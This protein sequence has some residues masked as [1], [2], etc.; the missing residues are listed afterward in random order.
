MKDQDLQ[1]ISSKQ[2]KWMLIG[3][4][5][6]ALILIA[7]S[8]LNYSCLVNINSKN[9]QQSWL[10][11]L[12]Y[13]EQ[14]RGHDLT[15]TMQGGLG[16]DPQRLSIHGTTIELSGGGAVDLAFLTGPQGSSGTVGP[17]GLAGSNGAI[18]T[19]GP[20]GPV[21]VAIAQNGLVLSGSTLELGLNPLLHNTTISQLGYDMVLDGGV[22]GIFDQST[23]NS[24]SGERH[25]IYSGENIFGAPIDGSVLYSSPNPSMLPFGGAGTYNYAL[26][27][28]SGMG[29][30][31]GAGEMSNFVF[32]PVGYN[33]SH[34][35]ILGNSNINGGSNSVDFYAY[36]NATGLSASAYF[37]NSPGIAQI[38]GQGLG[39]DYAGLVADGGSAQARMYAQNSLGSITYFSL[40]ANSNFSQWYSQDGIGRSITTQ[41][42]VTTG[43]IENIIYSGLDSNYFQQIASTGLV[44]NSNNPSIFAPSLFA[45]SNFGDIDFDRELRPGG[46][47][48]NFGEILVSQ[49]V[50]SPPAWLPAS[51]V[52]ITTAD[53]GLSI[54]PVGNVQLG[55][56]LTQNTSIDGIF[57]LELNL[58]SNFTVGPNSGE[59]L[60][61]IDGVGGVAVLGDDVNWNNGTRAVVDINNDIVS[62]YT[63]NTERARFDTDG[64]FLVN[65]TTPVAGKIVVFNGDGLINGLDF[66]RGGGNDITNAVLGQNALAVNTGYWNTAIGSQALASNTTATRNTAIGWNTLSTVTTGG[67]NTAIGGNA[68]NLTT[69]GS[70]NTAVGRGALQA[71]TWGYNNN[72]F[73]V[74]ALGQLQTGYNNVAF[75]SAALNDATSGVG[76]VVFGV[77]ASPTQ[78]TASFNTVIGYDTGWGLTTGQNNTILGSRVKS[79]PPTLSNTVIIADGAGNRR[80]YVDSSGNTGIGTTAPG[81]FRLNITNTATANVAQFNGSAGTQCTVVT[82]TGWSCTSD[83]SLKTNV[84]NIN[85]GVDIINQIQGVTYNWKNDQDGATQHGFIAQDI[86]KILPELVTTDQNGRLSLNKDGIMPYIVEAVKQQSGDIGKVN[87][88]LNDQGVQI[89]YISDQL[90]ALSGRVDEAELEIK[91]LHDTNKKQLEINKQLEERLQKLEENMHSH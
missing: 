10:L 68:L 64:S 1:Q 77:M 7:W 66:G 54:N 44:F 73:G 24:L 91:Q 72:A 83:E 56:P 18:G 71:N 85:N 40:D 36:D 20:S 57:D 65:T 74:V 61:H 15:N 75:G 31:D 23:V 3:L 88:Q 51:A 9:Q 14:C 80:I 45:V 47:A 33:M 35:G 42:N 34:N 25:G 55:G 8:Y 29:A 43:M 38:N 59:P 46:L 6:T 12:F 76:N 16:D 90:K 41:H 89:G 82:G 86:Q 32:F 78:T 58:Y 27:G 53:N 37:N 81:G 11:N 4:A 63:S 48:G 26:Q 39:S 87:S 19:T 50:G 22:G 84:L 67:S 52:A 62:F 13:G 30:N 70:Q 17:V 5:F 28:Q 60:L 79:L 21:G 69:T 49:G 2:L